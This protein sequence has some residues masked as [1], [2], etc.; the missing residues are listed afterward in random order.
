MSSHKKEDE[1][2][3]KKGIIKDLLGVEE[4]EERLEL[5]EEELRVEKERVEAGEVRLR[6]EVVKE[7]KTI[8][9]PVTHE[10][11]VVEK[12]PVAG[13]RPGEG[14]IGDDKEIRIPLTEEQVRVEKTPVVKEE[15]TLKKRAVQ[16]TQKV[17]DTVKREEAWV[18]RTGDAEVQT[19]SSA[20][21]EPWRGSERRYRH[22]KHYKGPERRLAN[23]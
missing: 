16:D 2:V 20:G 21:A 8:D 15:I 17:S 18:D 10:E 3:R 4:G 23:A 22:D 12:H 7:K 19:N 9:V 11:V 1:P 13:R 5:R 6:K 14:D